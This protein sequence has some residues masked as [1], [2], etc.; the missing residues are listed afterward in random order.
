L[1]ERGVGV[2][3]VDGLVPWGDFG[4][5]TIRPFRPRAVV[6]IIVCTGTAL[7]TSR[8]TREFIRDLQAVIA[9]LRR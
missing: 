4:A 3:L 9:N 8:L 6:D 1:V 2:A 7:P 5:L